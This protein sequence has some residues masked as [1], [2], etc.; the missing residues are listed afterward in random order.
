MNFNYI[1]QLKDHG[2]DIVGICPEQGLCEIVEI[3]DHPWM[4]GV[5]FHPEFLSKLITPHPLFVGFIQAAIL[6]SRNKTYV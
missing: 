6:H 3:K 5:Q 1:Q 4:I 2:L